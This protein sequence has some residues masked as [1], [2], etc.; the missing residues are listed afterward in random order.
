MKKKTL[1][2]VSSLCTKGTL[3]MGL[4]K[5]E[6]KPEIAYLPIDLSFGYIPKDFSDK[7]LCFALASH[8]H[9]E[10]FEELKKFVTTDYSQ[11][12]KVIVWHGLSASELLLLYLMSV[13]VE[14]EL[15]HVDIRDYKG[16]DPSRLYSDMGYVCPGDI[17]DMISLAKQLN[18]NAKEYCREQWYKWASSTTPYRFSN[19]HTGVIEEYPEDF[20]DDSI[21]EY[22]QKKSSFNRV[23]GKIMMKYHDLFIPDSIIVRRLY[24]LRDDGEILLYIS[25]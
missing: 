11:Y 9:M 17:S 3:K 12:E 18:F 13:L 21:K 5:L 10:V 23:V 20:M 4:C 8:G 16:K 24:Q 6:Q 14:G 25:K 22:V 1:H 19:I 2:V 15:Y 7:E